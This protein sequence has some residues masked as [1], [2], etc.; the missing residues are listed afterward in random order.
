[1]LRRKQARN[2]DSGSKH[3]IDIALALP[4]ET[5]L[6]RDQ[7]NTFPR[8]FCEMVLFE[9]IQPGEG[10]GGTSHDAMNACS[11]NCFAIPGESHRMWGF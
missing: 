6:I 8:E 11:V 9:D 7:A 5:R 2:V 3:G 10:L 4:I 1:M